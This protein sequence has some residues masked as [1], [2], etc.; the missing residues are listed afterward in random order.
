MNVCFAIEEQALA[1]ALIDALRKIELE[2]T[3][4]SIAKFFFCK[5]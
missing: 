2:K 4:A 3:N 1:F 5:A